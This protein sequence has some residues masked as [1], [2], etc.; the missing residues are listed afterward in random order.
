M[1]AFIIFS[2]NLGSFD[3][4]QSEIQGKLVMIDFVGSSQ[5]VD[6]IKMKW[7]RN[8][9]VPTSIVGI[10]S[11][12]NQW[13]KMRNNS[14]IS[15]LAMRPRASMA[16]PKIQPLSKF[17]SNIRI[18]VNGC[19]GKRGQAVINAADSAGLNI[20]PVSFGSKE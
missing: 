19:T 16:A 13:M 3:L 1:I 10:Y 2:T 4:C 5:H 12:T 20:V 6:T 11:E 18:M 17:V 9:L 7:Q 15:S 14:R 8:R